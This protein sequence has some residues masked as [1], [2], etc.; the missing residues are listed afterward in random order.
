MNITGSFNFTTPSFSTSGNTN[1]NPLTFS[2]QVILPNATS[3]LTVNNSLTFA[4]PL[5]GIPASSAVITL[6][7]L[8]TIDFA[9]TNNLTTPVTPNFTNPITVNITSPSLIGVGG[10][11]GT[12]IV[13]ANNALGTTG[14]LTLTG[15]YA[16][17]VRGDGVTLPNPVTFNASTF[18]FGAPPMCRSPAIL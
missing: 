10:A 2:S 16:R 12:V 11:F 3:T 5:T 14:T 4:G 13:G 18:T 7:D 9:Q 15:S 6:A 1:P 17:V 8:G